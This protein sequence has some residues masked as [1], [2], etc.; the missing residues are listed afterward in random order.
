MSDILLFFAS[1]L[2]IAI[3]A[4]G[5]P[6]IITYGWP[7]RLK[8]K[9]DVT[10]L[11]ELVAVVASCVRN[12]FASWERDSHRMTHEGLRFSIWTANQEFGIGLATDGQGAWPNENSN[13]GNNIRLTGAQKKVLWQ[14]IENPMELQS[15][16]RAR[17][18]AEE[19]IER[20]V[21]HYERMK[22]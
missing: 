7:K 8:P 15:E 16:E 21:I 14:A 4:F 5:I 22:P 11:D 6:Y 19:V 9:P 3:A 13:Y 1:A 12:D 20:V 18:F 2:F 10:P 17:L